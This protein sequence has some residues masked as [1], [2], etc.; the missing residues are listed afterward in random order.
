MPEYL[1]PGVYIEETPFRAKPINGV[2]TSTAAIVGETEEGTVTEARLI[3]SY[4][5][6]EQ[7]YGKPL[8]DLHLA[9]SVQSFFANGGS[10]L[11]IA[12]VDTNQGSDH[13]IY[14]NMYLQ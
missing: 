1:A 8:K 11:Y 4:D 3:T 9:W 2:S 7:H 6:F 12:R 14:S 5:E 13:L 10:R